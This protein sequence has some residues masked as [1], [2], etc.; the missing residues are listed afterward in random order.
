MT[1]IELAKK[2]HSIEERRSE[3]Y[4]EFMTDVWLACE[5]QID[6]L[7]HVGM[8]AIDIQDIQN[9]RSNLLYFS[10]EED[11]QSYQLQ[12]D[13]E[14]IGELDRDL[15]A[16]IYEALKVNPGRLSLRNRIVFRQMRTKLSVKDTGY[17]LSFLDVF[18][19]IKKVMENVQ[20]TVTAAEKF[21]GGPAALRTLHEGFY[22][23]NKTHFRLLLMQKILSNPKHTHQA[24]LHYQE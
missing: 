13:F 4:I 14:F 10:L 9:G 24:A 23:P 15:V 21:K 11:G 3:G 12:Y 6:R 22:I 5:N 2:S 18:S 19:E 7:I 16:I 8:A 20:K 17:K 1:I